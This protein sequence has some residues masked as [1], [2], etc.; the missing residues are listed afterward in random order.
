MI[1]REARALGLVL[2]TSVGGSAACDAS[3]SQDLPELVVRDSAGVS[4][5]TLPHAELPAP[6][7]SVSPDPVA[8][9]APEGP[10]QEWQLFR[11]SGLEVANDSDV[12]IANRG[13]SRIL[14][15]APDGTLRST[16]GGE[17]EG[18]GEFTSLMDVAIAGDDVLAL[19]FLPR[20]VTRFDADGTFLDDVSLAF[21]GGRPLEIWWTAAGLIGSEFGLPESYEATEELSAVRRTARYVLYAEDGSV[22]RIL[23]SLPGPE[24]YMRSS[25]V[26]GMFVTAS[27]APIIQHTAH[28]TV[29]GERLVTGYTGSWELRVHALD[30]QVVQ[31]LR[32]PGLERPVDDR[33][34]DRLKN[35]RADGLRADLEDE[36][37][38]AL[39][40]LDDLY[41]AP[42]PDLLPAFGRMLPDGSDRVWIGPAEAPPEGP[43]RWTVLDLDSRDL[44]TID[45]PRRFT[46]RAVAGDLA[47]GVVRDEFDVES[48]VAYRISR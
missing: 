46:L 45:L 12:L 41:A 22:A 34:W 4:L 18:P 6:A 21:E 16:A 38:S 7:W 29:V 48:V 39:Q 13:E 1:G 8:R 24:M 37:S 40:V 20:R 14:R 19:D 23:T 15:F 10:D 17:G 32:A 31:I 42:R 27:V 44:R 33:A 2:L 43:L 25:E 26:D 36:A 35:E 30:G 28:H 47:W 9:I 5:V 3:P 11:V